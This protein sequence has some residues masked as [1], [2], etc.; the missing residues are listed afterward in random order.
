MSIQH[1][2]LTDTFDAQRQRLN[3]VIDAV[4]ANP[5]VSPG[6]GIS[7]VGGT[8]S[9]KKR[10]DGLNFDSD[11]YLVGNDAYPNLLTQVVFD[12][13]GPSTVPTVISQT[14]ITFP[15][16]S[17][18]FGSKVYYGKEIADF[19]QIDVP[20]T[21]MNV[22][23][24]DNGVVFVYV[25]TS[26]E[27]HQSMTPITPEN[28]SVQ[29]LLGSYFRISN[30]IQT[31]SWKYTP[32]NGATSKDNRFATGGSVSGGLLTAKTTNTLARSS[33]NV[34]LEGVNASTSIYN[35]N[36]VTYSAESPY[37][38]KELW[39]GYDPS[40]LDSSTLDT[41]HIYNMTSHTVD[42]ISSKTGF[43]IL[44]P[45][46]VTPTGQD[47]YLMA[48]STKSGSNYPQIYSNM[49][50]AVDAIYGYQVDLGNVTTRVSWLGQVIVVK[51]GATDY[52]DPT[53]LQVI[54]QVPNVLGSYV[55][56]PGS[57]SSVKIEG[58]T[59]KDE[60]ITIGS[61]STKTTLN[62]ASGVTITNTSENSADI[63]VDDQVRPR[64]TNCIVGMNQDLNITLSNNSIVINSGSVVY[65]PN[66]SG[67][68]NKVTLSSN[69]TVPGV[70]NRNTLIFYRNGSYQRMDVEYCY[71]GGT[72]PTPASATAIWYDTT[73]NVI[74]Y[75]QDTGST[76][77]TDNISL[78]VGL[79]TEKTTGFTSIERVFNGLG[80]VGRTFYVLPGVKAF[81]SNGYNSDGTLKN[82][83]VTVNN[84][85]TFTGGG[86][87]RLS[88][89][90][91]N[92]SGNSCQFGPSADQW[93]YDSYR[94]TF[95]YTANGDTNWIDIGTYYYDTTKGCIT[96]FNS[97]Y[98]FHGLEYHDYIVNKTA[99][100]NK[101]SSLETSQ[102]AI[103]QQSV[104]T[105]WPSTTSV[106]S[107]PHTIYVS[108]S[109]A[110]TLPTTTPTYI[111]KIL[112]WEVLVKNTSSS[113]VSLTWPATYK[114]FNGES[115]PILIS[116]N[117]TLFFIM[118]K[119]SNNYVLVSSQGSQSNSEI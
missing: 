46:I 56:L 8:I 26:G 112:T 60:G 65:I 73:N 114:A 116:G 75:T 94:N 91:L 22:A 83:L 77:L 81:H 110:Y 3:T 21:T 61:E 32:W 85:I 103:L 51:I 28:S 54:G 62:F 7:A 113:S 41:T 38:T 17:V 69:I 111:D 87:D 31:N 14:G 29:C 96:Q 35:P 92:K 79:F 67:V 78:P 84:V 76:W 19:V 42:D 119:Y 72:A 33:I 12:P 80:F 5:A 10:G 63:Y 6:N 102:A 66:G 23:S 53:Q 59:I 57:A 2:E 64:I 68:F 55:S 48:M 52:T 82:D 49:N 15:A 104:V 100:D 105:T 44:I 90:I 20:S 25:D 9:V 50:D 109:S 4:N 98:A 115:L 11:G 117:T 24:G 34:V 18:I 30:K 99:T 107:W 40:A 13:N 89:L 108:V 118:R 58:L 1:V 45:G 86:N 71:S 39:P 27:I 70:A 106:S 47:V 16:F 88:Q 36:S 101:I 37:L 95:Y 97:K 43:I 93:V 74:K